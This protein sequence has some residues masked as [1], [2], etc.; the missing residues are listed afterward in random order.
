MMIIPLFIGF[1]TIPGGAGFLPST[2]V[3]I[4][5][6][7]KKKDLA[8]PE[9]LCFLFE[10]HQ[11]EPSFCFHISN[12]FIFFGKKRTTQEKITPFFSGQGSHLGKSQDQVCWIWNK[13]CGGL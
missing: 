9:S 10:T 6:N 5:R 2:V 12:G 1:L 4:K 7:F 11:P 13:S 3:P 8:F